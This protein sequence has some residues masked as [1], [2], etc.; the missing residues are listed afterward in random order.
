[1]SLSGLIE[2]HV[3]TRPEATAVIHP[4]A[5][6]RDVSLTYR[7]LS[8]AA[9][10]LAA[11]LRALGVGPGDRVVTALGPG[12][13]LVTAFLAVV[14]AG[15]A[16]VPVDPAHPGLRRRLI[17]RDSAARA[18]LTEG[19]GA[20]EYA[21]LDAVA[22]DLD[23][24]AGLIAARPGVLPAVRPGPGDAAY[25][26]YTSGTTGTPKGVVVPHRAVLDLVTST[27]YVRLTPDDVVA[28]AANPAFDAVTFEIWS[29]LA[30]GARLVGLAKDTVVDPARFAAAVREHGVST[31]FLTTALF[32]QIAR[33]RPDAFA[34]LRTVLFGGEACDPRRVRQV[35]AAGGPER[36]LHVYGPTETTTF[37]TWHEVTGVAKDA[38]TV[39]IG[40]PLGAT[41]AVVVTADGRPAAPGGSGEL[42]LGGP[43]LATG[44]LDRPE[45]TAQRF[46]E[47][48]FT[49]GGGRL[50]RTGDLVRLREDG[51]MEFTGRVDNQI[52]LRGFRIELGEIE[53]VLT[54]HPAV[55]EAVVSVHTTPENT[56]NTANTESTEST[57][58]AESAENAA[59][60]ERRLVAH[61]VPAAHRAAA[62]ESEQLTEWKEIYETLYDD[63]AG[64][65]YG[66]NFAGWNSSYDARPIPLEQMRQWRA[67]TVERIRELGGRRVLEIGVGTGLL[68]A[69]LAGAPECEEYWATDFSASVIEA[70]RAQTGADERL[71]GKV[72]LSCR[73]ADDLDG[74]PAGHFDTVVVNSVVQYFPHLA[75]LRSVVEGVLPLL[76]P[77][78][79]VLLG[80]VRNLDLAPCLQTGV[81]LASRA[82]QPRP[83]DGADVWRAV[84][85]RVA[86][87]T[88]LLLS[89]ALFAAWARELPAVRAVD[90][91]VK[92]GGAHN[93]LTRYRYEAVLSTAAP[94][95]DLSPAPRLVW[96]R[97]AAS[98]VGVEAYLRTRRPAAVRLAA[99]PNRRVHGEWTAMRALRD[100]AAGLARRRGP[101]GRRRE[102]A[103]PG[104]AVRGRGARRLP[105]PADLV[106]RGGP[107]PRHRL[108]RPGAGARR[109][110][111]RCVRRARGA[112][113]GVR[114]HA[115]RVREHRRHRGRPARLSAGAV[116]GLHDPVGA[117]DAGGAAAERQRQGGPCGAAR[118]RVQ[119]RPARHAA[120]HPASGDRP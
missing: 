31:V 116:A 109:S 49:S 29:T 118:A 106:G 28:Q 76:A 24:D 35:L 30:A 104:G 51:E 1:M 61:V 47:D 2:Q 46:V 16:Y 93:E 69:E 58:S 82:G 102:R 113:R 94:A 34:P 99:V 110:P 108:R 40:R 72:R 14:R 83:G 5:G 84:E 114:Q 63:A 70:L 4:S 7:E 64:A 54:A 52:K 77:G 18:V 68:M 56:A 74:L 39:P 41:V 87:E 17:V 112:R 10:R 6:G 32:H 23:A 62:R 75:Y 26:C 81:E 80:D 15:A 111:D 25:V 13:G 119:R 79:S 11:H 78:G 21:G 8:V 22:V 3:R 66:E 86:L 43:G 73:A 48:R 103:R 50:Y 65:A 67:A 9:N 27:D 33:E 38:R 95:L 42:L 37:A 20:G 89:P 107:A 105:G 12:P 96:G 115:D 44:Y 117:G 91:R 101:A 100:G 97:D 60:G 71:R 55:S 59:G 19:S 57:E 45:L 85:Q 90:V 98:P 92:R 88:E 36:Q 120:R 53:S